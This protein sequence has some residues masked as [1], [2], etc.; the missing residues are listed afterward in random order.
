MFTTVYNKKN[1]I[2]GFA[3]ILDSLGERQGKELGTLSSNQQVYS[4]LWAGKCD[5]WLSYSS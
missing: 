1:C 4:V 2:G 3:N 5:M